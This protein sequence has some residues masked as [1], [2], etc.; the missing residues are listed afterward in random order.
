MVHVPDDRSTCEPFFLAYMGLGP[1]PIPHWEHW[2]CPDAETYLTGID[3]YDYPRECRLKLAELYPQLQ[4]G[5]PE[6]DEPVARPTLGHDADQASSDADAHTVRWGA[7]ATATF[8]HGEKFF[9]S[10]GDVFAFSP[11]AQGDF[12]DWPVINN[13][14]F[15]DEEELYQEFRAGFPDQWGD[16]APE[17][18]AS[19]S[20]FY[21]TMFMWPMLTFGWELFLECCLDPRFERIM[22]EFAE[23]NRRVFRSIARLPVNFVVC[24]DDIVT[25]R[26]PVCSP[27]WMH[28]YIFPRYEEFWG[29]CRATGKEVIFMVD[30]CVD[31]Y[32]DDVLACGARGII[33]EPMTD[34]KAIA[35]RHEGKNLFLAGEGDNRILTRNNPDEIRAMVDSMIETSK[36]TDGYTM[37]IGNHMPWNVTP[38][39]IKTYLDYA[40]ELVHR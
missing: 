34:Y 10:A 1:D 31:A 23:I 36:M 33:S 38:E 6:T 12:R 19:A 39:G 22:D 16:T 25:T 7:G 9:K 20:G 26:G 28:K 24:H 14:D 8:E 40:A 37:C 3:Y 4:L 13:S 30:G 2:S 21:N 27:Q 32:A 15:R 35:R 17:G 29:L 5:L 11:L 18:S